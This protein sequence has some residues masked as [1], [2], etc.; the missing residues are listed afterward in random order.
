MLLKILTLGWT[1]FVETGS[2]AARA[3]AD[4]PPRWLP[5][6]NCTKLDRLKLTT[7]IT[8]FLTSPEKPPIF[9]ECHRFCRWDPRTIL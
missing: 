2:L 4:M 1:G 7:F 5:S 8:K 9:P 6:R 3:L